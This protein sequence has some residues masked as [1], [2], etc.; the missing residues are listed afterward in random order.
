MGRRGRGK[1]FTYTSSDGK[2]IELGDVLDISEDQRSVGVPF[3][4]LTLL[5]PAP[6]KQEINDSELV[7]ALSA[8]LGSLMMH[9]GEGSSLIYKFDLSP[10]SGRLSGSS[11]VVQLKPDRGL[12]KTD[13]SFP[14]TGHFTALSPSSFI[15]FSQ[16]AGGFVFREFSRLSG[17]LVKKPL[18]LSCGDLVDVCYDGVDAYKVGFRRGGSLNAPYTLDFSVKD[19]YLVKNHLFRVNIPHGSYLLRGIQSDSTKNKI[20][21]FGNRGLE[22]KKCK[23]TVK[24]YSQSFLLDAY[25]DVI[26]AQSPEALTLN[27]DVRYVAD[28]LV[29]SDAKI[30][31]KRVRHV[32]LGFSVYDALVDKR[33]PNMLGVLP[34][35]VQEGILGHNNLV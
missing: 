10:V 8:G 18:E 17:Q 14:S 28:L 21:Y 13:L 4:E 6:R 15:N 27:S 25:G 11:R 30:K 35:P 5:D 12:K 3:E 31:V 24:P 26:D 1:R 29:D 34:K 19:P 20:M 33:G 7:H 16:R 2:L 22:K 23:E 9:V 32:V